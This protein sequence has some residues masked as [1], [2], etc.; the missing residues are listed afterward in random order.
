MNR[1][2]THKVIKIAIKI[3]MYGM[4]ALVG[5]GILGGIYFASTRG[6]TDFGVYLWQLLMDKCG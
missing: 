3:A 6:I 4:T 5:Y 1:K 2:F